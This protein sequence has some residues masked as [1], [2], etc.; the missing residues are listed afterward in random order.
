M[1]SGEIDLSGRPT[2]QLSVYKLYLT[3]ASNADATSASHAESPLPTTSD[4]VS[5]SYLGTEER[6]DIVTS[7]AF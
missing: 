1:S 7:H 5:A 6:F 3:S 4:T 2:V